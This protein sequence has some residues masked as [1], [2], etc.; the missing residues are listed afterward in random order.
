MWVSTVLGPG[1][2]RPRS[3]R[4]SCGPRQPGDLQFAL[5]QRRRARRRPA[6]PGRVRRCSRRWPS[7]PSSARPRPPPRRAA[8][9]E[10]AAARCSSAARRAPSRR[11]RRGRARRA[12]GRAPPRRPH[13]SPAAT[14]AASARS[15]APGLAAM[16]RQRRRRPVGEGAGHPEARLGRLACAGGG[17]RRVP[18]MRQREPA[19][20]QQ[21][22]ADGS[23]R[24]GEGGELGPARRAE[25]RLRG[26]VR[27]ARLE[28]RRRQRQAGAR[29]REAAVEVAQ[30]VDALLGGAEG[31]L[32]V[33]G[34]GRGER[35]REEV[36]GHSLLV[37]GDPRDLDGGVEHL[38]RIGQPAAHRPDR[39]RP[40][41]DR[42]H[43][44]LAGG[45][46]D[47]QRSLDVRAGA[48]V[49]V[50]QRLRGGEG[51]EGEVEV[52]GEV[53]VGHPVDERRG[54]DPRRPGVRDRPAERLREREH[55][56]DG[57]PQ[58]PVAERA[59]GLRGTGRPRAH[60]AVVHAVEAVARQLAHE[61][62][63]RRAT[64]VG[65]LPQRGRQPCVGLVMVAEQVLQPRAGRRQPHAGARLGPRHGRQA[66]EQAVVGRAELAGGGVRVRRCGEQA[67]ARAGAAGQEPQG[68][69]EQARGGRRARAETVASAASRS[70]PAAAVSPCLAERSTWW[71]RAT[72]GAPRAASACAVASCAAMRQPPGAASYTAR[73]MRG[74]RKRK[75]RGTSVWPDEVPPQQL[76][77]GLRARSARARPRPPRRARARTDRRP[78]RRPRARGGRAGQQGQLPGERRGDAPGTSRSPRGTRG[79]RALARRPRRRPGELLR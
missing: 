14:A 22:E 59:C 21:L 54:L 79:P 62:A 40:E 24:S 47:P 31:R 9:I 69:V 57:R 72:A 37:I 8:R 11:P 67:G 51:V 61:H 68:G 76:V 23:P 74:W 66:R 78:R 60:R 27:L 50:E 53:V 56:R 18:V 15:A 25:E 1:R 7:R 43:V 30:R 45:L 70:T 28:Q 13:R 55:P 71:A 20:R 63:P 19:A 35:A 16:Q 3:A 52:V 6:S 34:R 33:A 36:P 29:R 17:E 65:E 26:G 46:G 38:G 58:R 32:H 48:A 49:V 77:E 39:A 12:R 75:R 64:G 5:G 2:A 10:V 73:R 42:Q 4:W 44:T 41:E